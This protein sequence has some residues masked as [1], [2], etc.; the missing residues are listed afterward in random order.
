MVDLCRDSGKPERAP[1]SSRCSIGSRLGSAR[2]STTLT[3]GSASVLDTHRPDG[4]D[5]YGEGLLTEMV[6]RPLC[7]DRL[8]INVGEGMEVSGEVDF[9][10]HIQDVFCSTF[11]SYSMRKGEMFL[12]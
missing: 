6:G 11:Y 8:S 1:L 9:V 12:D 3:L 4:P 7:F 10:C 5:H 2:A